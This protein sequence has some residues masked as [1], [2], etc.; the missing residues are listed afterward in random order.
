MSRVPRPGGGVHRV[1]GTVAAA[2]CSDSAGVDHELEQSELHVVDLGARE[3]RRQ[4]P[5]RVKGRVIDGVRVG[6]LGD[7]E[8]HGRP[9]GDEGVHP[10]G[11][12]DRLEPQQHAQHPRL[13]RGEEAERGDAPVDDEEGD[14]GGQPQRHPRSEVK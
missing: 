6:A 11:S 10:R 3:R 8:D 7:L 14:E 2:A 1:D 13:A 5:Q 9:A 4:L 12:E